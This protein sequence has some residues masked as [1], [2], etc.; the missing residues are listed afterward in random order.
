MNAN[1]LPLS[2]CR[3]SGVSQTKRCRRSCLHGA[4]A[5]TL[6]LVS[7]AALP[8]A[9]QT[10]E[11][12]GNPIIDHFEAA[13]PHA[14][15][16]N[17]RYYIYPTDNTRRDPGFD[18]WS[19][20]NLKDW[21]NEGNVLSLSK[22]PFAKGRPWA[23]GLIERNGS[24]YFYFSADDRIGVAVNEA[25]T[26]EFQEPL[27][28]PLIQYEADLS[29]IDPMAFIDDDGQAYLY[30]GAVPGMFRR[31]EAD[32]IINSLMVQMLEPDMITPKGPRR[33]TVR[34]LDHHIEG[35]F[36]FKRK[37]VYY[38]MYSAGNYNEKAGSSAAYRVEYATAPSPLGPFTR[39]AN[40]PV[41]ASDVALNL[42]SPGHNS[43]LHLPGADDWYIIYHAHAG[44]VK[45]RVYI[46]RMEFEEDGRIRKITPTADG[47]S[48]K[49][50]RV[51][52]SL[53][54]K[55][56][57]TAGSDLSIEAAG[58]GFT[59]SQIVFF[60]NDRAAGEVTDAPGRFVWKNIPAGFYRIFARARD[61]NGHWHSS[62]EWNLDVVPQP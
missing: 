8:V 62:C 57:L 30:Y 27:G 54:R 41:L 38:L 24:Y 33:F 45:R 53:S 35:S 13:D 34:A 50:I 32:I 60:A 19:S 14:A 11:R 39:A 9:A 21:R 59:P 29:T 37:G 58:I 22:V 44:D 1:H 5:L 42:A 55:G 2:A 40:N 17:N 3:A 46:D 26:G 47:V 25:P 51:T 20:T 16:V 23:P 10:G 43:L 15:F 36:V 61:Q 56:P 52:C 4:P 31:K 18:V 6:L 49:P 7:L 48:S 28:K 12:T